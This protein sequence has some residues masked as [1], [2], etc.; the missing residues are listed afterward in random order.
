MAFVKG[1]RVKHPS[2]PEWGLGQVLEDSAGNRVHVF[3]VGSGEKT[4][5]LPHAPLVLVRGEE[6]KH[7]GLDYL[8]VPGKGVKY[9]SL[10]DSIEKFKA[11]FPGG[12]S[13]LRYKKEE[14]D[15]KVEAHHL[16]RRLLDAHEY[17]PLLAAGDYEEICRRA[18]QV[19][20]KT[21]L[22]FPNEKMDLKDG[23]ASSTHQRRLA[24]SLHS[25]LYGGGGMEERFEGF[26]DCLMKIGAAKWTVA[27]YFSFLFYPDEHMFLKP[28]VTQDAAEM[29]AFELNYRPE[30]NWLTY[31][32]LVDFSRFLKK[33]LIEAN[34]EPQDMIDVQSFVWCIAR[35]KM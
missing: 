2:K 25:L 26:A 23:L 35:D 20:N 34:L 28:S 7:A 29:C 11:M 32:S 17:E 10:A 19:V 18:L 1:D 12:F 3:F 9:R 13:S 15:Y 31:R 30:P 8:K 27:T 33:S 16:M 21:N 22:I 24:E 5:S 14:R 6:A 4:L